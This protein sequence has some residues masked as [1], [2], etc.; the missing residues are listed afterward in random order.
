MTGNIAAAPPP[1]LKPNDFI[2]QGEDVGTQQDL[3]NALVAYEQDISDWTLNARAAWNKNDLT[4]AYD[5]DQTPER[6]FLGLFQMYAEDDRKDQSFEVRMTS[7]GDQPL[8]GSMGLYYFHFKQDV[9]QHAN[10]GLAMG[11]LT[12]AR[13]NR[14]DNYAMFGGVEYDFTDQ[15]SFA[16]EVR[17]AR[18]KKEID[19]PISCDDPGDPN[20]SP[21][22]NISDDQ[23]K[24]SL[25]PRFTL[26]YFPNTYLMFYGQVAKGNK[27]GGYNLGFF[28]DGVDGCAT[29]DQ[30]NGSDG[31][32]YV[33]EEKAWNYEV[34]GKTS[35]MDNRLVANIAFFYI[36]WDNQTVFET[37]D[38]TRDFLFAPQAVGINAGKSEVY[39]MELETTFAFTDN[40]IGTFGYGLAHGEF[41][42]YESGE[43]EAATGDGDASG[44]KIPDSSKHNFVT[45]LAYNRPISSQLDWFAR[46]DFTFE[47]KKYTSATNFAEIDD[48]RRW[49]VRSGVEDEGWRVS[50][51]VDNILDE[52]T[53]SAILGFPRLTETNASGVN[54]Q[55]YGLTPTPGRAVGA[56]LILRFGN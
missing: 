4:T 32:A 6:A 35:W 47:S 54:P 34:G 1:G 7:P 25:T 20:F 8:R 43:L 24:N 39:G 56:E 9:R 31:L 13:V 55:G 2:S 21:D 5:L 14:T 26:R 37:V 18:D 51:F 45:S 17:W 27:P 33:E 29:L 38:I 40:L 46:T 22:K 16:T 41:E 23:G 52:Q 3:Y 19:S 12:D 28:I 42:D 11:Q 10:V 53:P 50:V 44:N 49:N 36:D 48:R 30:L 15:W